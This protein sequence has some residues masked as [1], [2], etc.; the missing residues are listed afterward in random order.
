MNRLIGRSLMATA[1]AH[2]LVGVVLRRKPLAAIARDGFLNAVDPHVDRQAAFWFMLFSPALFMLHQIT[3]RA[4]QRGDAQTLRIAGRNLL[5]ISLVGAAA[6]PVS[7]FWLLLA[8]AV[9]LLKAAR[10]VEAGSL[11][12]T[13]E[14][15]IREERG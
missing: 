6:M 3:D 10:A 11:A 5:G 15:D 14:L 9:L 1:I 8:T 4:F 13:P 7:G 12:R 2:T